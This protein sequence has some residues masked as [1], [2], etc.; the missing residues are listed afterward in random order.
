[1]ASY[2][3]DWAF[4]R[5]RARGTKEGAF[6]CRLI[7]AAQAADADPW[8]KALRDRIGSGDRE[9]LRRLATDERALVKQSATSLLPLAYALIESWTKKLANGAT[10]EL[11]G[12]SSHPSGPKTWWKPDGSLLDEPPYDRTGGHWGASKDSRIREFAVRLMNYPEA[13]SAPRGER[14]E[15]LPPPGVS[16]A[17]PALKGDQVVR[18]LYAA[19]VIYPKDR[20]TC[21]VRFGVVVGPWQVEATAGPNGGSA[22]GGARGSYA[23]RR[24]AVVLFSTAHE[25]K[26]GTALTVTH[27]LADR[28]TRVVAIDRDGKIHN[29]LP[30]GSMV[31]GGDTLRMRQHEDVFDLPLRE[32]KEYQLQS[33]PW[34]WAEFKDVSLQPRAVRGS[35]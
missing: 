21:T 2:L 1:M 20:A 11:V 27:D 19:M 8:R 26:R 33:A 23:K 17:G 35:G 14:W 9:A 4:C 24:N 28:D 22:T 3:D 13:R 15:F 29:P 25:I 7:V 16:G 10:I 12:V 6:W 31:E 30:G 32:I 34:E 5:H 18:D